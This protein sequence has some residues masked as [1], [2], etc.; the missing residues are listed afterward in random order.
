M[1]FQRRDALASRAAGRN[2]VL[3][4]EDALA[5]VES[6]SPPQY[7]LAILPLGPDKSNV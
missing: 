7:H 4:Y 2:N 1:T 3:D 5:L 6:K